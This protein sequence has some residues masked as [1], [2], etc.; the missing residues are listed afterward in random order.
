VF[1]YLGKPIT[2]VSTKAWYAPLKRAGIEDFRWH[3]LRHT[4]ASWHVQNGTPLCALQ[5]LA[6]GR[7]RRGCGGMRTLLPITWRLVRSASVRCVPLKK[8]TAQMR[9][10]PEKSKGSHCCK[11][12]E[13][14]ET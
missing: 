14:S 5:E 12:F 8:P 10:R 4:W 13:R 6:A 1:S 9:H 2:Q 11:P 3:D 7:R